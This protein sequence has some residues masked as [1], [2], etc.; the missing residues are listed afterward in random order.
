M[1]E[2]LLASEELFG[3]SG[4]ASSGLAVQEIALDLE[5][6][7]RAQTYVV[8]VKDMPTLAP[9]PDPSWS[10]RIGN[11]LA[12]VGRGIPHIIHRRPPRSLNPTG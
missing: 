10:E 12:M 3:N 6:I 7:G 9:L 1:P 11:T 5:D 2:Y 8:D 4:A